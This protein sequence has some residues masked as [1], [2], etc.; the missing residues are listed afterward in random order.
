MDDRRSKRSFQRRPGVDLLL[1]SS[2]MGR[3]PQALASCLRAAAGGSAAAS[4]V[5]AF[6]ARQRGVREFI[7]RLGDDI[8]GTAS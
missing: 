6:A 8:E 2:P 4:P 5:L 7:G 1:R 3:K